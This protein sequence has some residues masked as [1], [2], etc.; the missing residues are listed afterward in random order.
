MKQ[1]VIYYFNGTEAPKFKENDFEIN[2]ISLY[3][4]NIS[5]YFSVDN[6]KKVLWVLWLRL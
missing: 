6:T 4:R 2:A 5:K 1:I 3:L